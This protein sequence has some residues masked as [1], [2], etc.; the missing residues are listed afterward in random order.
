MMLEINI[1]T[2]EVQD[3]ENS[4]NNYV[5]IIDIETSYLGKTEA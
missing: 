5:K 2:A 4:L 1:L 3:L